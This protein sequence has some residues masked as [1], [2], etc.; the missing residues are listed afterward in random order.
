MSYAY[1]CITTWMEEAIDRHPIVSAIVS[2]LIINE[3][4]L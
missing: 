3:V 2:A 1:A 4:F